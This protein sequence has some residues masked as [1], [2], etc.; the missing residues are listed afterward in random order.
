MRRMATIALF[1]ILIFTLSWLAPEIMFNAIQGIVNRTFTLDQGIAY[2]IYQIPSVLGYCLPI[3]AL[4]SAVFLF[5]QLSLSGELIAVQ[6]SGVSFK[7]LLAPI[8]VIGFSIA[9]LFFM[10]Q[11]FLLPWATQSLRDLNQKTHFDA[12]MVSNPLV[13]F[14]EKSKTGAMQKFLI[15]SPKPPK[16][17][18]QFIFLFYDGEGDTTRISQ[19]ITA[20]HGYWDESKSLWKLQEGVEYF[21]SEDG[22]YRDV[23]PFHQREY[24]TSPVAPA[25][26]SFPTGNPSE[27]K[28]RQ[29][30][31][32]V[33]LL[34]KGAQT[35]DA[36][37]Y[38]VRLFQRYFLPFGP[39][40]LAV[41]GTFIGIERSRSRRN[42]GLT[43]AAGLLLIY[44]ILIPTFTTLGSIGLLPT[45]LAAFLPLVVTGA[46]GTGII[47]LRQ[48]EG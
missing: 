16:E 29:L 43:Y 10:T 1:A 48:S 42:L 34:T 38:E 13:T 41:L 21:L 18:N 5:R 20:S 28:I 37:F 22:I 40:L 9:L 39:L 24:K 19:I 6:A 14:V 17:G 4:F 23:E 31:R 26:L 45:L 33:R 44:N 47:K 27:F 3:S 7:R 30:E 2:L 36:K 11:E 25:L 32:Y 12:K 8:I 15:I 35:E 46:L